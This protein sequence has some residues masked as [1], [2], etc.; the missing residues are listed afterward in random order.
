MCFVIKYKKATYMITLIIYKVKHYVIIMPDSF[1]DK[2][3]E[4]IVLSGKNRHF[5]I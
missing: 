1:F 4:F 2:L 5:V 3:C